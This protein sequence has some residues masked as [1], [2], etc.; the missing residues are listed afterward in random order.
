MH[1]CCICITYEQPHQ[2]TYLQ[3]C[4][5]RED[6]DAV[7]LYLYYICTATSENLPSDMCSQRRFR[8]SV[9]VFVLYMC[10]H[11]RKLTFRHVFPEKIQMQCCCICITYELPHQKTYL[12]TCVPREDSDAVLLYLYY[13]CAATSENLPSV[14][15]SQRRF[16]CR[17]AVFV[18]YLSCHIR[19]LTL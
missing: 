12:Q 18:L 15:C 17:I 10:C 7:L 16:G 1:D 19:K 14:M 4:V 2:K 6:S 3:T 11:I 5:P 13:I 8:C 9:A